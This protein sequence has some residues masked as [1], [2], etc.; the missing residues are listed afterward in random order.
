VTSSH[1]SE[2]KTEGPNVEAHELATPI[3]VR[4]DEDRMDAL[5][6]DLSDCAFH[7]PGGVAIDHPLIRVNSLVC[8]E[9]VSHVNHLYRQNIARREKALEEKNWR[10]YIS[11]HKRPHQVQALVDIGRQIEADCDYWGLVGRAWADTENAWESREEW[12]E[13]LTADRPC[14]DAIMEP[15]EQ[16]ARDRLPDPV[17]VF[18]GFLDDGGEQGFAWTKD[19]E[20]ATWFALRFADFGPGIPRVAEG[21]ISRAAVLAYIESREESEILALP[22]EIEVISIDEI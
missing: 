7:G 17:T 2:T 19:Q 5:D 13:L 10:T 15:A 6:P 20:I 9:H 1:G 11:I 12:R 18:R 3:D 8:A 16:E 21:R 14:Q 4:I 22:E